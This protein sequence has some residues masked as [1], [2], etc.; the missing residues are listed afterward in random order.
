MSE[1]T[2]SGVSEQL[3]RIT[4]MQKKKEVNFIAARFTI[5]Q[6]GVVQYNKNDRGE[7]GLKIETF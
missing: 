7:A 1:R 5:H 3:L 6:I 2:A 4:T